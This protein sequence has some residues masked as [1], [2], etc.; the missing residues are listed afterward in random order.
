[1]TAQIPPAPRYN[2]A[3]I[4]RVTLSAGKLPP[5]VTACERANVDPDGERFCS[6][7][8]KQI[9]TTQPVAENDTVCAL[10]NP[11]SVPFVRPKMPRLPS[12]VRQRCVYKV[13]T[14]RTLDSLRSPIN[15]NQA[16]RVLENLKVEHS[17]WWVAVTVLAWTLCRRRAKVAQE[18][19]LH[20]AVACVSFGIHP[21]AR[22]K[23]R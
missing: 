22:T 14:Q 20:K 6:C 15:T 2:I 10:R 7:S 12:E 18:R 8:Q 17:A 9:T 3:L 23:T 16:K 1:M 11:A 21:H 4:V 5:R 19:L 13:V